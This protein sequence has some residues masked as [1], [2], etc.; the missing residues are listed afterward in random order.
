L[1]GTFVGVPFVSG[2]GGRPLGAVS[3]VAI[4]L[5]QRPALYVL[6]G[7]TGPALIEVLGMTGRVQL[8]FGL[9]FSAG[10]FIS[11]TY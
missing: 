7:R 11:A 10:L 9:A 1:A 6:E 3:L 2:L 4:L 8:V 5:A